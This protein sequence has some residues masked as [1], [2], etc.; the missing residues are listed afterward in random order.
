MRLILSKRSHQSLAQYAIIRAPSILFAKVDIT[1]LLRLTI[2]DLGTSLL[3][4][5][6]FLNFF[7]DLPY[8]QF[9]Y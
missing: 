9:I 1:V 7:T 5:L 6:E 4:C 3:S 2:R 8:S